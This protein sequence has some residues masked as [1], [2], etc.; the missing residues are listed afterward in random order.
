MP[1]NQK[2]LCSNPTL[3]NYRYVTFWTFLIPKDFRQMFNTT[4]SS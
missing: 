3:K 1:K 4:M 2:N